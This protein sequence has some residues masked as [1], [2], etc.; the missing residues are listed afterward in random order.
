MG[1]VRRVDVGGMVYHAWNRA[2]FRSRL[3]REDAHY[4][5]FLALLQEGVSFVPMRILAYCLMP[6]HWHLVLRPRADGDL[7]KF[8]QRITLTHTQRYHARTRTVGYGHVYQGRYKSLLVERDNH[9]LT[10]VRYVESNARRAGL[11]KR[12]EDWPWSSVHVRFYGQEE[13]RKLLSPWPV[14]EPEGYRQWLNRPQGKEE[15][16]NIR[17]A[18]K[19]SRPYGSERWVSK[20]VAQFG[21]ET[22]LRNPWR[23]RNGTWNM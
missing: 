17:Y 12:A 6:N 11:V 8:L 1:R 7:G 22:T 21:L 19:R 15:V 4:E 14:A 16:E 5:D 2:N 13:E 18:I 3:F 23:P 9:F 10:L 20:A